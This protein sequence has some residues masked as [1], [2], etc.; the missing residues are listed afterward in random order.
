VSE[1]WILATGGDAASLEQPVEMRS[2]FGTA[3]GDAASL[4]PPVDMQLLWNR[5]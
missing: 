5:R 2:F 1:Y 4:E 3:G